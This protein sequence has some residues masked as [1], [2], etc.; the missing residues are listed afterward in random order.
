MSSELSRGLWPSEG[1]QWVAGR[2][3]LHLNI[4]HRPA[5]VRPR[6]HGIRG[7]P[8]TP[9]PTMVR[10]GHEQAAQLAIDV[11][12]ET[13]GT[14]AGSVTVMAGKRPIAVVPLKR[15]KATWTF[16]AK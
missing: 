15:G 9:S 12:P 2:P 4:T 11:K 16:P 8:Y 10:F 7:G 6:P 5:A 1:G 14:P 13:G 3:C